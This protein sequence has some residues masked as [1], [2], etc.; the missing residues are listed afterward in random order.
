MLRL[1]IELNEMELSSITYNPLVPGSSPG[2]PTIFDF[3]EK[4]MHSI[5]LTYLID[6]NQ[7][8]S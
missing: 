8:Y 3:Y 1:E 7:R 2:G 5:K 6:M 4:D